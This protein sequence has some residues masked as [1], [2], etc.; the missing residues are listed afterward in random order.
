MSLSL[1][2]EFLIDGAWDSEGISQQ[3]Q[4][5]RIGGSL[6]SDNR[7]FNGLI[8][9]LQIWNQSLESGV[10]GDQD[11]LIGDYRFDNSSEATNYS[12]SSSKFANGS[13][14]NGIAFETTTLQ[15]SL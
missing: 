9:D 8:G 12:R 5:I 14:S 10:T 3:N 1:N 11:S 2:D 15:Y 6:L 13:Y 4:S 7:H